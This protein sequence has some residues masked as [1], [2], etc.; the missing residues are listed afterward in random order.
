M[1]EFTIT[2]AVLYRAGIGWFTAEGET[3]GDVI[4]FP[5]TDDSIDDFL[6]TSLV[7]IK[8]GTA[9]VKNLS[10][11]TKGLGVS[12]FSKS[13]VI[14]GILS[15]LRGTSVLMSYFEKIDETNIKKHS[16]EG[17]ILGYQYI[18]KN[19]YVSTISDNHRILNINSSSIVEIIP[20]EEKLQKQLDEFM[21]TVASET[22]TTSQTTLRIELTSQGSHAVKVLFLSNIPAW[23]LAYRLIFEDPDHSTIETHGIVD[24]NT[25]VDWVD[26]NLILSTKV[27]VSFIYD[28][29]TPHKIQR[30]SIARETNLGIVPP[31]PKP[32][33]S[34]A[35][36]GRGGGALNAMIS[37]ELMQEQAVY[38]EEADEDFDEYERQI[39][40][41][42]ETEIG[43]SVEYRLSKPVTVK[44]NESAMV[45]LSV[46]N[47]SGN[48]KHYYNEKNHSKHPFFVIELTNTL[49]YALDSGPI[50]VYSQEKGN[51]NFLGEAMLPRLGNKEDFLLAYALDRNILVKK[52]IKTRSKLVDVS[53]KN[54]L[55]Y[56]QFKKYRTHIFE[57]LN[58]SEED[59]EMYLSIPK[60][61]Y[62]TTEKQ[63]MEY[64]TV[65][66]EYRA[67]STI[68]A[69]ATN[70]FKFDTVYT[71]Q[72][73][74]YLSQISVKDL[75][76]L[77]KDTSLTKKEQE[78]VKTVLDLAKQVI[79]LKTNR[80]IIQNKLNHTKDRRSQIISTLE[81]LDRGG[82]ENQVRKKYI[83]EIQSLDE[84]LQ[85]LVRE[86]EEIDV[87]ITNLEK[88]QR[89]PQQYIKRRKKL[90]IKK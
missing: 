21:A 44:R 75:E 23:K 66:D 79:E 39:E 84:N 36:S 68:V 11:E 57:I 81:V 56:Y 55:R 40:T 2:N 18:E 67:K 70:E 16:I 4:Y 43:E 25:L 38:T 63:D 82:A 85:K 5:V 17:K 69:R 34:L 52:T 87:K 37:D 31:K 26:A 1:S 65:L 59:I 45:P 48:R 90:N 88:D 46:A 64:V 12:L 14:E 60:T 53:V 62:K 32:S 19:L 78:I 54:A 86:L 3:E 50:S 33:L 9:A 71:Y 51:I 13:N 77:L 7:S 49:G 10:F 30:P 22:D 27:P 80:T 20:Q 35:V 8:E 41:Q 24:N 6:K 61:E 29:S 42:A 89:D 28:L 83:T 47:I 74:K 58:R 76:K 72:E 73:S 15:L